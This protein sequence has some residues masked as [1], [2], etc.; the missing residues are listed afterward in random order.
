LYVYAAD[1]GGTTRLYTKDSSGLARGLTAAPKPLLLT[2][3][4]NGTRR[5]SFGATITQVDTGT[6]ETVYQAAFAHFV[7]PSL[8]YRELLFF[9]P[10]ISIGQVR[11]TWRSLTATGNV[12]WVAE[13]RDKEAGDVGSSGGGGVIW[14]TGTAIST[15]SVAGQ[16]VEASI[17]LAYTPG[18][19]V[20]SVELLLSRTTPFAGDTLLDS[21]ALLWVEVL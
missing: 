17:P 2:P 11:L 18:P 8:G 5:P 12:R 4:R 10:R 3:Q 15:A 21:A 7:S 19:N 9:L 6:S 1:D 20:R 16:L 14:A 13:I